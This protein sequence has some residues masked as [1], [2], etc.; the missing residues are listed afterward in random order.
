[1]PSTSDLYCLTIAR[2]TD[3]DQIMEIE[4]ASFPHPW[5]EPVFLEEFDRDFSFVKV[6]RLKQDRR[7]V[8]FINY[9]IVLDEIHILNVATHPDWRRKN[10]GR[11]LLQHVRRIAG[12]RQARLII[13]EVRR[14]NLPAITLYDSLGYHPIGV[15]PRYYENKEDAIVMVLRLRPDEEDQCP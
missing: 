14:S 13:L 7:V 8:A 12:R 15:R 5:P 9:W 11:R 4:R 2:R 10:L 1:V 6:L 3:I